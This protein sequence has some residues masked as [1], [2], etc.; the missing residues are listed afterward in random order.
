MQKTETEIEEVV[1][2]VENEKK[3]VFDGEDILLAGMQS[4]RKI[5]LAGK[6]SDY[7]LL[8]FKNELEDTVMRHEINAIG[9]MN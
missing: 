6:G 7:F 3:F 5:E 4:K 8:L 2:S 1:R 9:R